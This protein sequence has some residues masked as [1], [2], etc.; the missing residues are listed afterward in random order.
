MCAKWFHMAPV[1]LCMHPV[2]L[3][4]TLPQPKLE[5]LC[6]IVQVQIQDLAS[7]SELESLKVD[8][9]VSYCHGGATWQSILGTSDL[10]EPLLTHSS[11]QARVLVAQ[12]SR[13]LL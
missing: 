1:L 4:R 8:V 10:K 9:L 13:T 3:I 11:R 7:L 12:Q 2:K 6:T 5:L